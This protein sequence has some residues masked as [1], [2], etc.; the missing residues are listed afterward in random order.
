[1]KICGWCKRVLDIEEGKIIYDICDICIDM[2][3]KTKSGK[4]RTAPI[5]DDVL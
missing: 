3:L 4:G 2:E 5:S 1:M